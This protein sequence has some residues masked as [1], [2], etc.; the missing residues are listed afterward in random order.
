MERFPPTS[1]VTDLPITLEPLMWVSFPDVIVT[2]S[3]P[4]RVVPVC[5]VSFVLFFCFAALA[6]ASKPSI[7]PPATL[8]LAPTDQPLL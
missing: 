2:A 7:P 6:L 3:E 4:T 8:I 5:V 1:A